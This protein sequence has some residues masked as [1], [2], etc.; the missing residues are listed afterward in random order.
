MG[1]KLKM[2][3]DVAVIQVKG[4]LMGGHETLE[5]HEAIRKQVEGNTKKIVIDLSKVKWLN[6]SGIGMLMACL[7]TVRKAG[8]E[9]VISGATEKVNSAFM[10]TKLIT[11]FQSFDTVDEAVDSFGKV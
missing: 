2:M 5:V 8:G 10:V 6:S 9:L 4:K 3:G 7:T 11:L 1:C